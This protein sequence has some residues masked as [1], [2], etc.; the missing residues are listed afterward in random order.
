MRGI[1]IPSSFH[2]T[3]VGYGPMTPAANDERCTSRCSMNV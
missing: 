1:E 3:W 2:T